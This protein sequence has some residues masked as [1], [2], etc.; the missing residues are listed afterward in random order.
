MLNLNTRL[1]G[2]I[3]YNEEDVIS[4]PNG[5][6][7]FEDER[8]FLLLNIEG[9]EDSMFCLQSTTTPELSFILMNP[10]SL[11]QSYEPRLRKSELEQLQVKRDEELCFYVLCALKRPVSD[12]TVNMRCPIVINPD[13]KTGCQVILETDDFHMRHPLS[14]FSKT[15]KGDVSC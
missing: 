5:L 9:G 15:D 2:V 8:A 1:L 7:S 12:S 11:D 13:I 6:P 3:N 4:F 14:E 10:F